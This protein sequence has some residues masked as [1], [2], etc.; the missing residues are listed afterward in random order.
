MFFLPGA[1]LGPPGLSQ[2]IA[3]YYENLDFKARIWVKESTGRT[4]ERQNE[5]ADSPFHNPTHRTFLLFACVETP[6]SDTPM[7]GGLF[8][9]HVT[10]GE[11][12]GV[13]RSFS[14]R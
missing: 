7:Q 5:R 10:V 2:N 8:R 3:F 11:G 13:A 9:A 12:D 14:P 6:H 1:P 4:K